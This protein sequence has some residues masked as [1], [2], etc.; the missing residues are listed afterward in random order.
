MLD[1][2]NVQEQTQMRK[3]HAVFKGGNEKEWQRMN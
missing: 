3:Y 2:D 1:R